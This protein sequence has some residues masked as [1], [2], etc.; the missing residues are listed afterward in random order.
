[1]A[2]HITRRNFLKTTAAG[3]AAPLI[4][5]NL[6]L[7]ASANG[8]LQH[9]CVGIGGMGQ[10]DLRAIIN[11][12]KA[13][14]IAVCDIDANNLKQAAEIAPNARQY[15]DWREMLD[16]EGDKIDSVNVA[17]PDHMHAPIAM[18]AMRR[19]KHV[20]CQKPMAHEAFDVRRMQEEAA[21]RGLVT[22]MG[23]QIHSHEAYRTAA[24]ILQN[25]DIGKV[26]EWHS[27]VKA[28]SWPQGIV[29]P[30]GEDPIPDSIKW[31]LWLGVAPARPFKKDVY[32]AFKWRGWKDFG[33][34][35]LGDFGCH[36]FDPVF[37]GINPGPVREVTAEIDGAYEETWPNW[38]IVRYEFEGSDMTAGRTVKAT[39]YDGGKKP[40]VEL[41]QMPAGM[42]L[43][44]SGS[45]VIG[46]DGVMVL[47]HFDFPQLFPVEKF[48]KYELPKPKDRIDHYTAWVEDC[49]GKTGGATSNFNYAGPLTEAIV[50]GN[51]ANR[52][53]EQTLRWNSEKLAFKHHDDANTFIK[54]EYRDGWGDY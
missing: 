9:A 33:S 7:H 23:N 3:F 52:F 29:R 37:M 35:A 2:K 19:D 20:Y 22:Q 53:P 18:A 54:R 10:S 43:P 15:R 42:E 8:R 16:A 1:M 26:K 24:K 50:I 47:K 39:W 14:I 5:P 21:K 41:A 28:P 36:I 12:K 31:D 34:G 30:A 4:L 45:L 11:S 17:T 49:L 44:D 27:W 25:G 13:D 38:E 6:N 51:I 46:E 48:A 40:P 32:H